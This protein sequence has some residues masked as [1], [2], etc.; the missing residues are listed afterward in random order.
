MPRLTLEDNLT[1]HLEKQDGIEEMSLDA[2]EKVMF[3][4]EIHTRLLC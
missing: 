4:R 3:N 2:F 1:T